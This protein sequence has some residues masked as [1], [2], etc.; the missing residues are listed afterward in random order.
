MALK[1]EHKQLVIKSI[2]VDRLLFDED[3]PRLSAIGDKQSQD[4]LVQVLW[5]EMA[6]SEVA[7]S[8]EANG[9]FEEEPLFVVP[10]HP[11]EKDEKKQ[12]YIV[13]EGNRRLAVVKL[14]IDADLRRAV[15]A[16]DLPKISAQR[17]KDLEQLPVS[18]YPD[19]KSLWEYFGFRHVNGPKEWDSFSKA[20]YI[21]KVRREWDIPL[22]EIARKIGDQHSTVTRIYRG[23]VLLEQAE[24]KT[25][26]D[27]DDRIANRFH[28]S[29]LYTAAA[30]KE[31]QKFLNIDPERSLQDDPVPKSHLP[32]LQELMVWLFGSKSEAK[33]PVVEK[34]NPH[35]GY[36]KRVIGNKQALYALRSGISLQRAHEISLGDARRFQEALI[37]V[38]CALQA[39]KATVTT[40][41]AGDTDTCGMM[42]GMLDIAKSISDEMYQKTR[43]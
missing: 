3:N 43:A 42:Y 31:F 15:K 14:L 21:A 26:F 11:L 5:D 34:Q 7:L 23:F 20:A 30:E 19:K 8:I 41:F 35:L 40:G 1:Y 17:R 29:H 37:Q 4:A 18:V 25:D 22:D 32:Q 12:K 27:R 33:S 10:K 9:Y 2:D 28:F 39:A 24:K 36:L 13:V 6:V 38:K 16:T